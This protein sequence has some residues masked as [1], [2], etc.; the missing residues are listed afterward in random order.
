MRFI[1]HDQVCTDFIATS[2]GVEELI[3]VDLGRTDDEW[4][5][6]ILFSV[7]CQYSD[8]FGAK[9]VDKFLVLGIRECFQ[10]RGV[11]GA[12]PALQKP[13]DLLTRNPRLPA[14]SRRRH[15]HV[16]VLQCGQCFELKRI[17]L[18]R[19]SPRS[20]DSLEQSFNISGLGENGPRV[21]FWLR[22]FRT[23]SSAGLPFLPIFSVISA[24]RDAF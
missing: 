22:S 13:P 24:Q 12:T 21:D 15:Q 8:P 14:A 3:A 16:F 1:E 2:Q 18:E 11:P 20:A 17:G 4:S 6:G 23:P 7:A 9:L 19:S 5:L 10:R